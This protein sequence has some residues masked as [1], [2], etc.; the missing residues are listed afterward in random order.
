ML[1]V[2]ANSFHLRSPYDTLLC[3]RDKPL[4][5]EIKLSGMTNHLYHE[6]GLDNLDRRE[7]RTY[8]EVEFQ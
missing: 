4:H 1:T 2:A 5:S 6:H 7:L 3:V 8:E